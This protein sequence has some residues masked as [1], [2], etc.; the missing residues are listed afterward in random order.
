M[1]KNKTCVKARTM[2]DQ[3][4]IREIRLFVVVVVFSVVGGGDD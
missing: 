2:V 4:A 1:I 3:V